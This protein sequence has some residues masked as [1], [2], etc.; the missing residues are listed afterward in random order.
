MRG[1]GRRNIAWNT[2]S[3]LVVH[4]LPELAPPRNVMNPFAFSLTRAATAVVRPALLL[5]LAFLVACPPG[6]KD[7]PGDA[8]PAPATTTDDAGAV[9]P[10]TTS[11]TIDGPADASDEQA[12]VSA[13]LKA[14][15][16]KPVLL[17]PGG[18]RIPDSLIIQ[19]A[20]NVAADSQVGG[21]VIEGTTLS[22]EPATDGELRYLAPSTLKFVPS[23]PLQPDTKYTVKL[24]AVATPHAVL[25]AP[26]D[27]PAWSKTFTT[28]GF[29]VLSAGW[30]NVSANEGRGAID[31]VFSGPIST[32]VAR[33]RMSA[34]VNGNR[35]GTLSVRSTG[36]PNVVRIPFSGKILSPGNAFNVTVNAG[37]PMLG[38]D[39]VTAPAFSHDTAY[40]GKPPMEIVAMRRMEGP[41]G[42]FI[43]VI[44]RDDAAPD[45]WNGFWDDETDQWF[46]LTTRCLPTDA[47]AAELVSVSPKTK[48]R[49]T[50]S[51][52]GFRILGDF[53][54][55]A[56]EV[57]LRAG[58]TTVDDGVLPG[59][60]TDSF[61]IPAR[62]PQ[63]QFVAKGRYLPASSWAA[64]PVKH[65]NLSDVQVQVRHVPERNLVHWLTGEDERA[66]AT[67][68]DLVVDVHV[69]V[70]GPADAFGTTWLDLGKL[71]PERENGVYELRIAGADSSDTSR[72]LVTGMH[73]LA[74]RAATAPDT[75]HTPALDVWA[76][77]A[78]E[79][80]PQKGATIDVRRQSGTVLATCVTGSAGHC[81][82]D[83][84]VSPVDPEPPY[85]I[86][87]SAGDDLTYLR[88]ADL[89]TPTSESEVGGDPYL[90]AEAYRLAPY[91]DRGVYRPGEV[92]HVVAIA[93]DTNR[94]A[95]PAGMPVQLA[96][97]DPRGRTLG[98]HTLKTDAA[99]L[100]AHDVELGD[101]AVT[102]LYTARFTVGDDV[103]A[104]YGFH[105]EEFVPE[106]MEVDA[107][108]G[109]PHVLAG[110]TVATDINAR[111]LFGGSAEGSPVE[112]SCELVPGAFKPTEN[113]QY[114]YGPW[115]GSWEGAPRALS[116][117]SAAGELDRD[118]TARLDCP[119]LGD[120]AT[121]DGTSTLVARVAV[122]EAG[123]GRSTQNTANAQL[124]PERFYIGL[125]TGTEEAKQG[126]PITVSGVVV[127][128]TG[129]LVTDVSELTLTAARLE[130]EYGWWYDDED[131]YG[132]YKRYQRRVTE[133]SA[134]VE[135]QGGRFT[136]TVTPEDD[137]AGY[138]IEA[139]KGQA[140]TGLKLDGTSNYWWW[141]QPDE[142]VD[143]TP[144][145]LKPGTLTLAMPKTVKLGK[146]AE[147]TFTA[148]YA[149]RALLAVE[150][151]E[152]THW[153][154][155]DAKPGPNTW[156]FAVKDF[157]PNVYVSALLLKDPHADS[158]ATYMPDRA[159][160]VASVRVDA[161][162]Y[163]QEVVVKAPEEVQPNSKLTVALDLPGAD[164]G[165]VVTVAAVDEGIL[166]LTRFQTPDPLKQLLAKRALGVDSFETVGWSILTPP[167]GATST[168]GGDGEG[169]DLGR[170]Q[171]VEPVALW[172]GVVAVTNGKA[173]V[174]FD[175]PQYRGKLRI[176]AI[177]AG[178]QAVG[179]AQA[180]V[181]VRDPIVVQST[182]PRFLTAG[183]RFE[184]PVH[185]TNMSGKPR[186]VTVT[187]TAEE[188]GEIEGKLDAAITV[189]RPTEAR[190]KLGVEEAGTVVFTATANRKVGSAKLA[191]VAT[192]DELTSRADAVVPFTPADPRSRQLHKVEL[193]AGDNDL[194]LYL[195]GWV[196]TT[197]RTTVRV[198]SNPYGDV[199]DHLK[200]LVR[201]PYGCIEQ[202]TS[203]TRPMLFVDRL[204]EQ[205]D[206]E[207]AADGGI[208]DRVMHGIRRA[209]SMQTSSGGFGYWP[210]SD[211][212]HAWAT[213]YATHMLLDAREVGY[214]VPQDAIDNALT[215]M[216]GQ[217]DQGKD[218]GWR[219]GTPYMHYVLARSDRGRK[220]Q[221][222][223]ELAKLEGQSR[224]GL[225][226]ESAYM[227]KAALW[228][229]GDRRY[230]DDLKSPDVSPVTEER[231]NR[232]SFYSDRRRRALVL[233][234][235]GE[236]FGNDPSGEELA[237]LVANALQGQRS[238]W[239]TTQEL[240]WGVTGLGRR[241]SAG[242]KEF[243]VPALTAGGTAMEP[244]W[245]DRDSSERAW[246]I[247]RL[248]ER[249]KVSLRVD[250]IS[251]GK[252][253]A[254]VAS[255]GVEEDATWEVG[256]HGLTVTRQ[257]L[258][259]E[260][261]P[262]DP[263]SIELGDLVVVR[264]DITNTTAERMANVALVDRLPA[265]FEIENAN[266]GRGRVLDVVDSGRIW[267]RDHMNVRDD[268]IEAFGAV[269]KG[270]AGKS[271]VYAVR[272]TTAG[273]FM[274]PPVE[275]EA[276]YDPR[277]WAREAGDRVTIVGPWAGVAGE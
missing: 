274:V 77:D 206:P 110:D 161:E 44:C 4:F 226:R 78:E 229:A 176:M 239:Y 187:L 35:F 128:W 191:V 85:V 16:L 141:S 260:G 117:G 86:V 253:Y 213:A 63:V 134:Q 67:T 215:Y 112:L 149:G 174:E 168:T 138:L 126:Q 145:P 51:R 157:T 106:R 6:P 242:S 236:L 129:K 195:T 31:V 61:T 124:H 18:E 211:S 170:V 79:L 225:A 178:P 103:L 166:Q 109:A 139:S 131:G 120:E 173:T 104:S 154:W 135:V 11:E 223:R 167:E 150:T 15:D 238:G 100:I 71:V 143:A 88:F 212:P 231:R 14:T 159:F 256:G 91:S 273:D 218:E 27:D 118:G 92:A 122:F 30:R 261:Q 248:G 121:I 148:P 194:G 47:S 209:L 224:D 50:P 252:L 165:T 144:K 19:L 72:V 186:T 264:L 41:S 119:A 151:H 216:E 101:Y 45:G 258:T 21:P 87:A 255:E 58:L 95:P 208:Q 275:A 64:V 232:W 201:Y 32:E 156:S 70:N 89:Q 160:G 22:I 243:S 123:S 52:T 203:S 132:S 3:K 38:R 55:G 136:W 214:D 25:K 39:G 262:I 80:T 188:L 198:T 249:G 267:Q 8:T 234:L 241:V 177:A 29:R 20:R 130:D 147:V 140:L 181:L 12:A 158:E 94:L 133:G 13:A 76:I 266:L 73:L 164:A 54:R 49:V 179:R 82:L 271:L 235:H 233:T 228:H 84:E 114:R 60:V 28:P 37:V 115:R 250:E 222:S 240:M 259:P 190:L 40:P 172:S 113:G 59:T 265:G 175:I 33:G 162:R 57:T 36:D 127:D 182:L 142:S 221:A 99:G 43:E 98:R 254:L 276:M 116:L 245:T 180:S 196:P 205:V 102:G 277:N 10:R 24:G 53:T 66:D 204:M 93:R 220:A 210:G 69:P 107:K 48:V 34:A 26:T 257:Y 219:H 56:Y 125:D 81:R 230:E 227:L 263:T 183:D 155:I 269:P 96:V 247:Q 197:E 105:V 152:V 217:V 171:P 163:T 46:D 207:M 65:L 83:L 111:Y 202:T 7:D 189:A 200:F 42:F 185:V 68:S 2:L 74:K 23:Q 146:K 272:A 193:T 184:V 246:E 244:R 17:A 192:A 237:N 5:S 153:E 62:S 169:A 75:A 199:F 9:T 251:S 270:T 90:A 108:V 268:R 97:V 137:G 1:R